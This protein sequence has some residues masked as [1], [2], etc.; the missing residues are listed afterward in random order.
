MSF[1]A[2]NGIQVKIKR[3][4]K[5]T[6]KWLG[7]LKDLQWTSV[8]ERYAK[9]GV[10]LLQGATPIDTGLTASS[11]YSEIEYGEDVVTIHWSNS[12]VQRGINIA[13]ILDVGHG[14]GTGGWVEGRDYINPVLQPLFDEMAEK[15]W[16]EVTRI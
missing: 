6:G 16:S 1:M 8:V 13:L 7:K 11:W 2:K 12:N 15:C 4:G 14:T 9:L 3:R 5:D 10:Q